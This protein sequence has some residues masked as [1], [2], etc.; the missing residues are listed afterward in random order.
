MNSVIST[1]DIDHTDKYR[2]SRHVPAKFNLIS[3]RFVFYAAAIRR[4]WVP[5]SFSKPRS[6]GNRIVHNLA[7]T[8][9]GKPICANLPPH[10]MSTDRISNLER[11]TRGPFANS[12]PR[13]KHIWRSISLLVRRLLPILQD[14]NLQRCI[15]LNAR[16]QACL[17]AA[18][19]KEPRWSRSL[20]G[21]QEAILASQETKKLS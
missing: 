7:A 8:D 3:L 6:T 5:S 14:V 18:C 12:R 15:Q 1:I 9:S 10:P 20:R 19:L 4:Q 16:V 2:E 13:E 11:F 21:T 17:I